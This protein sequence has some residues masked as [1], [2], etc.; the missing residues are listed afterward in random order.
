[1]KLLHRTLFI[2]LSLYCC[3][4]F[5]IYCIA[6]PLMDAIAGKKNPSEI[7]HMIFE[8]ANVN[9]VDFEFLRCLKPVLRYALD[10][11]TDTKSVEIIKMLIA[12]GADV[13]ATTYNR[14]EDEHVYGMMPLLTYAAIHSSPEIVQMFVN[15]GAQDKVTEPQGTIAFKQS[16]LAIAQELGRADVAKVLNKPN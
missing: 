1:M 5:S 14:V 10:R 13:N 7:K 11:G 9:E 8:G 12:A 4:V 3:P 16:A 15:A 6:S 2:V